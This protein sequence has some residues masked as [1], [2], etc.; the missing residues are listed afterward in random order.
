MRDGKASV[1]YVCGPNQNEDSVCWYNAIGTESSKE[2]V[3][4]DHKIIYFLTSNKKLE[5]KN[6]PNQNNPNG[7]GIKIIVKPVYYSNIIP[8]I[9]AS[10]FSSKEKAKCKVAYSLKNKGSLLESCFSDI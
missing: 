8:V 1:Q 6:N 2:P 3:S 5:Y 7:C 10:H 4:K 9:T